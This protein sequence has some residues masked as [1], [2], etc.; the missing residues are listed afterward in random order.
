MLAIFVADHALLAPPYLSSLY[1]YYPQPR[2]V[3]LR[4]IGWSCSLGRMLMPGILVCPSLSSNILVDFCK[5]ELSIFGKYLEVPLIHSR[6]TKATYRSVVD[7]VQQKLTAW[8]GKLLG[9]P[10]RATLS[11]GSTLGQEGSDDPLEGWK[12]G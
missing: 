10:G 4:D 5:L 7:K 12:F 6:I 2:Q 9:L 3:S 11:G 1:R 8:K